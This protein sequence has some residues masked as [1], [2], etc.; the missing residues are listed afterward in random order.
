MKMRLAFAVAA[1]LESDILLLDEVL[2]VGDMAFQRKCLERVDDLTSGG[3]T[4]F[5][6]SHSMDAVSRYC[7]RCIWIDAGTIR[8]DGDV[9]EAISTY[10][11]TVM[12]VR[13]SISSSDLELKKTTSGPEGVSNAY[14]KKGILHS[15]KSEPGKNVGDGSFVSNEP[16]LEVS[17]NVQEHEDKDEVS[18]E[19]VSAHIV[20][21]DKKTRT[22]FGVDESVCIEM[23][24]R[25]SGP[26][27]FV[28]GI[29]VYCP[30]GSMIFVSAPPEKD[31]ETFRYSK[32]CT[33]TARVQLPCDVLNIGTYS[34]SLV[35]FD[36]SMAPMKRYFQYEQVL[37]FHSIE[38]PDGVRS[39]RGIMPRDFAGPIRPLLD[40]TLLESS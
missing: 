36:P 29:H 21:A 25:I 5:F 38:A 32:T 10:V 9:Q 39:A 40:W 24:Y 35:L 22:L 31:L 4:L 11:E 16:R 20:D 7:D 28:P 8:M 3:R 12:S 27:M 23:I 34:V 15:E 30:Q 13:S 37:S 18:A 17:D 33:V 1:Y 2:A 19:L 6:V 26:G 14:H